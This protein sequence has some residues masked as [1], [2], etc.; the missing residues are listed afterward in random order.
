[1]STAPKSDGIKAAVTDDAILAIFANTTGDPPPSPHSQPA[2][3]TRQE[4]YMLNVGHCLL[5]LATIGKERA[6]AL[7]PDD[8]SA[9]RRNIPDDV[10]FRFGRHGDGVARDMHII[11]AT[12][13][14]LRQKWGLA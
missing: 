14:H 9:I 5:K 3:I 12:E 1:M 13:R 8:A 2:G 10:D 7:T 4:Q 11:A 6:P